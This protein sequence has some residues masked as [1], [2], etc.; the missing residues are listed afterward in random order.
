MEKRRSLELKVGFLVLLGLGL[1]AT[2]VLLLGNFTIGKGYRFHVD[3]GFTGNLRRGA[4]VKL[5]GLDV[6]KVESVRF[7]PVNKAGPGAYVRVTVWVKKQL[8]DRVRQDAEFYVNTKGVL[9]EQ[10]LEIVPHSTSAPLVAAGSVVRGVNPPRFDLI[11]SRLYEFLERGTRLLRQDKKT[12]SRLL[13]GSASA[14]ERV[15]RL[16]A[17]NEQ[18]LSTLL[19]NAN[20]LLV[21]ADGLV[22]QVKKGIGD[23]KRIS[24]MI[25]NLERTTRILQKRAPTLLARGQ[26]ALDGVVRVASL[27]G[28][29]DKK[30]IDK[31]LDSAVALSGRVYKMAGNASTLVARL[32]KGRGTVGALLVKDELYDDIKELVRDLKRNPWKFLWRE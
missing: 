24:R 28:A 3:F 5:A 17:K 14:V 15:D 27:I 13:K 19:A 30:R 16:L 20:R 7:L 1:L 4:L 22:G 18:Q 25:G 21:D 6:G 26:D 10:Y 31:L 2:F 9:G 32:S 8:H 11:V 29:K 12:I 23:P